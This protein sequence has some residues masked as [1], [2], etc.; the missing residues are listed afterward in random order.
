VRRGFAWLIAFALV[1]VMAPAVAAADDSDPGGATAD[2]TDPLAI[3]SAAPWARSIVCPVLYAHEV[4]S[5]AVLRRFLT[6]ILVAGFQPTSLATVDAAMSGAIEPPKNCVVLTFDDGLLSQFLNG[7][8]VLADMGV[9]AVFFVLPGFADGVHR[10]MGPAELQA[11]AGAGFEVE[12]HTCNHPNL[13]LLARRDL[14][15]FYAE[16][17]DCRRILESIIGESVAYI[18]YPSGAYDATVLDAVARFGFR[19]GFTTRPAAV[20][21]YRTPYTLPRIRYDPSEAPSAVIGR[22]RAAG[23]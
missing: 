18:A 19:A 7:L 2:Q 13:P 3:A 22:I 5:Q 6:G 11:L 21:N 20:L 9:P 23:G 8:P 4:V 17:V 14:N 1:V 10:Y 15:A 16:L 12:L